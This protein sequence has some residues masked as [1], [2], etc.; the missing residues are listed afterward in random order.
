MNKTELVYRSRLYKLFRPFYSGMGHVLMFHRVGRSE[1][2]VYTEDLHVSPGFLEA[3]LQYFISRDI[4][5]VSL[6][7][8]HER[9][10]SGRAVKRFVTFTFDDGYADNL[11]EALP[12]FEKYQAPFA[13]FLTTGFPDNQVVLWWYHLEKLV[14][15]SDQIEFRDGDQS[16][17]YRTSTADEKNLAFRDIRRYIMQSKEQ[18]LLHRLENIFHTD[19]EGLLSLTREMALS[20]DQVRELSD[21]PLSTV[22]SH[23]MNHLALSEL[24]EQKAIAEIREANRIIEEQTGRAVEHMAYPYGIASTVG[25]RE[26]EIAGQSRVKSAFTTESSNILKRH[27]KNLFALPRIEMMEGLDEQYLDMYLNGFTPFLHKFV[28]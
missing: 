9:L 28:R 1:D 17:F 22:G 21:H 12:V 24:P 25:P 27:R 7:D 26:F 6:D 11:T 13:V 5:V 19:R 23:T 4:D 10:S 3:T 20:W 14:M 18:E 16:Y 15:G 8:C 2:H